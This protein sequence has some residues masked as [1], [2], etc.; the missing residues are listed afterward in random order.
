M[1]TINGRPYDFT[2]STTSTFYNEPSTFHT[3]TTPPTPPI[4]SLP[5]PAEERWTLSA[6]GEWTPPNPAPSSIVRIRSNNTRHVPR[7]PRLRRPVSTEPNQIES[8][9]HS[10]QHMSISSAISSTTSANS[11]QQ[12]QCLD[13]ADIT[14]LFTPIQDDAFPTKQNT[15]NYDYLD[16]RS[17]FDVEKYISYQHGAIYRVFN[18]QYTMDLALEYAGRRH[19]C[20][21]SQVILMC[22]QTGYTP[23]CREGMIL[24]SHHPFD[25]KETRQFDNFTRLDYEQYQESRDENNRDDRLAAWFQITDDQ[26]LVVDLSDRS[27]QYLWIK[28]FPSEHEGDSIDLLYI[29]FIGYVGARS[30]AK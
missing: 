25:K 24:I 30:F 26:P 27:G 15:D 13:P 10:L 17:L 6:I 16:F 23:P 11:F 22:P 1:P 28:L 14:A 21:V 19:S 7:I 9:S 20:V 4:P 29:G 18:N 2:T 3:Y 8:H 5:P 12:E